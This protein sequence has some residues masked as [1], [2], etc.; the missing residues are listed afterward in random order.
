MSTAIGLLWLSSALSG[1]EPASVADY[2]SIQAAVE[3]NAGGAVYVPAGDYLLSEEVSI[4]SDDTKLHGPGRL[5]QQNPRAA[6]VRIRDAKHVTLRGLTLTRAAGHEVAERE[7]I[8]VDHAEYAVLDSL[9]VLNNRAKDGA[10]TITDSQHCEVR[11]C[12]VHNYSRVTV[13]DRTQGN[14][15]KYYGYAFNCI[16]GT[17]IVVSNCQDVLIQSSRVIEEFLQATPEIK[18]KYELGTFVHRNERRGELVSEQTWQAGYVNNWHQGSAITISSPEQTQYVRVVNNHI[19]NAAQGIDIHADHVLVQ[20]NMVIDSFIGMKAMHGSRY[21]L[22]TNNHFSKSVLWA[23]GLMPGAASKPGN[24]DGD[25]VV[26]GNIISEFGYGK[27]AWIWPSDQYTCIPIKL[28][29]G[30]TP[31]N[32]PLRNVLISGN[33]IAE[34][35][36]D[37]STTQ[38]QRLPPKYKWALLIDSG[39]GGPI[40]VTVSDDNLF[41]P[42]TDGVRNH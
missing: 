17:G 24:E 19:E 13:D 32:P 38:Q 6:I 36:S 1:T 9:L 12:L 5:I 40:N 37:D 35:H 27:A 29:R 7:G 3:A 30:Q 8:R 23:I 10:I 20:G 34:N 26:T 39:P 4:A 41:P 22:I 31:K 21:V 28:E 2:P 18:E 15:G 16:D 25:S 33:V 11:D 42:G 14:E